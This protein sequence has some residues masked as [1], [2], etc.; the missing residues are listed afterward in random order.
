MN[1]K[2]KILTVSLAAAVVVLSAAVIAVYVIIFS[3]PDAARIYETASRQ[4]AE[5]KAQTGDGLV[6]YGS[7]VLI[8]G[9]GYF[10]SNAHVV[11]YTQLA[12]ARTFENY[13]IRFAFEADYRDADLI[14]FDTDKDVSVLKLRESVNFKLSPVKMESTA[15]LKAGDGVFAVGNGMNH[16][17]GLT[18]GYVSLPRVNIEYDG[19]ARSV[20]QCDLVINEGNSGGALLNGNGGLIGLT[21]FRIKDGKGTPIYGVAFCIPSETL[22]E[23]LG[24]QN[25]GYAITKKT[26]KSIKNSVDKLIRRRYNVS[27]RGRYLRQKGE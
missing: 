27:S 5:L 3:K 1:K 17:V 19:K 2:I 15:G 20:I 12:A 10:V 24:S 26:Q 13:Y 4:V 14:A 16:G 22:T 11:T 18:R 9:D 21:T 7:A 23:Y 6:S 8:S 25:I